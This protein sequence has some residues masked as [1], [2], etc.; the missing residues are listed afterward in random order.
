MLHGEKIFYIHQFTSPTII[1]LE[2][3]VREVLA[4]SVSY[5]SLLDNLLLGSIE[6]LLGPAL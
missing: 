5:F 1:F 6:A 2:W 3:P 4:S